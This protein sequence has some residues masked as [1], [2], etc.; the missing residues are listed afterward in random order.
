MATVEPR[1]PVQIGEPAPDFTLPAV[2]RDEK[3]S[4][5]DYRGKSP[6]LLALN[7]GLWCAFCRRHI[8]HLG[9]MREKLQAEGVET[10]AVVATQPERARLYVRFHPVSVRL[11]ADPELSTHQAYGLPKP[12]LTPEIVQAAQEAQ[13][14][15]SGELPTPVSVLEAGEVLNK[16]DNFQMTEIDQGDRQ[17]QHLTGPQMS[18]Q[19]LVDRAGIVRWANVECAREGVAGVGKFPS[20]EE[21]LAAVREL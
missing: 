6:V 21:I 20:D 4:L 15:A 16:R 3:L 14:D 11:A 12:P 13:T 17:R 5:S 19:F 18:G 7:R 1:A 9:V 8:A 10:L 2:D